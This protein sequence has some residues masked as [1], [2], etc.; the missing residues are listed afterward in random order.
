MSEIKEKYIENSLSPISIKTTEIIL[1]QMKNC[2][3]KIHIE[4]NKGTGFFIKLKYNNKLLRLL[5]TSN[6]ILNRKE[7]KPGSTI[8]ISL[9]NEKIFKTIKIAPNRK[10]YTNEKFDITIIEI[11]DEDN[12]QNFL[13]LD[14]NMMNNNIINYNEQYKNESIYALNYLNG[15]EIY[16]SLGI[17]NTIEENKIIHK[18]NLDIGSSGSPIILLKNNK[19]IGVHN[20]GVK[21]NNNFNFGILIKK[22]LLEYIK[23]NEVN[24]NKNT[25]IIRKKIILENKIENRFENNNYIIAEINIKEEDIGKKV[26]IINSFEEYKRNHGIY[27]IEEKDYYLYENEKEIRE[28]TKIKLNNKNINF[29]YFHSFKEKGKYI[30]EYIFTNNLTKTDLMFAECE[31]LT[32]I[33]LSS[34]NTQNITNMNGMFGLC[35]SLKNINLSNLNTQKV[36]YMS[37]MF[38]GCES[39][40]YLNLSNF[41][42][43]KVT[44]MRSMFLGCSSLTNINLSNFNTQNV[45]DMFSMFFGCEKIKY[46]NL[47]NFNTKKVTNMMNMFSGC[48]N[49][50][51]LNLLN[52][53]TQNVT[54]M[55]N[56][57]LGCELLKKENII[58][59]D[60]KLLND[61]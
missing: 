61:F 25:R 19:V 3:C 49:L 13:L 40:T 41:N 4:D 47:S 16:T 48:K 43:Q 34:F 21:S 17:L 8:N 39:L 18:C 45:T 5:V 10:K 59:K 50:T 9:N 29:N 11:K 2:V 7:I 44:D 1:H 15:K 35:K 33:N 27:D 28:K 57:F 26:R 54:D 30:I 23:L 36:I 24:K 32:N 56:M 46:L 51:N 42:T 12:I 22:P 52:F 37:G 14:D 55:R 38:L 60:K 53:N 58:T 31:S 6:H 20:S